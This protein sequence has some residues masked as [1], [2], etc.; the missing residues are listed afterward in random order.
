MKFESDLDAQ[1]FCADIGALDLCDEVDQRF[2]PTQHQIG[3]FVKRRRELVGRL[4]DFNRSQQ[5]KASWR[6]FRHKF[7]QGIDRF[8]KSTK[9][10]R[11]HREL[12]RFLA[13]RLAH[14]KAKDRK[15]DREDGSTRKLATENLSI[16]ES[17]AILKALS[18]AKTHAFIMLEYYQPVDEEV[19]WWMFL[20]EMLP[21]LA[22]VEAKVLD[23]RLD[24][25]GNEEYEVLLRLCEKKWLVL[26]FCEAVGCITPEEVEQVWG[27]EEGSNPNELRDGIGNIGEL[28]GKYIDMFD[29]AF[30]MAL[31]EHK[32]EG[33]ESRLYCAV[34]ENYSGMLHIDKANPTPVKRIEETRPH[35]RRPQRMDRPAP[36]QDR[37]G[38]HA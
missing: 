20:E 30:K 36:K 3:E 37:F 18:S 24:E 6:K 28:N 32:I 21:V 15:T 38:A 29:R 14:D 23:E 16:Y 2:S 33:N 10:K 12:G 8:K 4:R 11:F 13:T 7:Q 19:Q 22:S 34:A 5:T 31:K 27:K 1:K 25:I 9:A 17:G 35:K 26:R